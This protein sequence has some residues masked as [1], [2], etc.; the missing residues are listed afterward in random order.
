MKGTIAIVGII[1]KNLWDLIVLMLI[2]NII[3]RVPLFF[4]LDL[5]S[6]FLCF[7]ILIRI[8]LFFYFKFKIKLLKN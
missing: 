8:L 6:L 1:M 7:F 3:I 4:L 5:H 2:G